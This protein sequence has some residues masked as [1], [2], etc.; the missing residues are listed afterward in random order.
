M[1]TDTQY[2]LYTR[3]FTNYIENAAYKLSLSFSLS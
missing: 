2:A 3:I 1:Y